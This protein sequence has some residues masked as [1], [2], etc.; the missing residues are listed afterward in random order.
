MRTG[1]KIAIWVAASVAAVVVAGGGVLAYANRPLSQSEADAAINERLVDT[2]TKNDT[3]S[4]ALFAAYDGRTGE[5]HEYAAGTSSTK[6]ATTDSPFHAAS[7]GKTML[8]AV[9][10]QLVDEGRITLDD[11]I[12]E[13]LDAETLDGLFTVDGTDHSGE[14][15]FRHLLGHTSG[16]ADYFE[17]PVL[18][19]PSMIDIVTDDPDR[20]F[21][22]EDLLA[23]SRENQ[24]PVAA[25][26]EEFAYSDTGY[27][28]LG[29]ALERIEQQPYADTLHERIF[30]PLDMRD[31][32]LLTD[33][34]TG[35]DILPLTVRGVDLSDRAALS[36]DWAGGGVVTTLSDLV[37][38]TR[39]FTS[40]E[41]FS[42]E[43]LA[44]LTTFTGQYDTGIHYGLGVMQFRFA[45]LSP[46]LF[47]MTDMHGAVG[48]T[49]T[50]A[51]YDPENDRIYVANYGSLDFAQKAIE[52]LI[53]LRLLVER[54]AA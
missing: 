17:G 53:Q 1:V 32:H 45:E 21:T 26:G 25:P 36:V 42:P 27:I 51:L 40:A 18:R 41:L 52:E 12:S 35:T 38:F 15:T 54:I 43:M 28:L 19:G 3:V 46:M 29:L 7:V 2:V 39:A 20:A 8:A 44:E 34:G 22:P 31:S 13:H 33:H 24:T 4:A 47:S 50:Y 11:P 9:Y 5:L 23:F 48:S 6:P 14:V 30:A 37:T 10:A 16:I 49:G